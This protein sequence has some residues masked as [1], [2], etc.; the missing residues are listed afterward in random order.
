LPEGV[1]KGRKGKHTAEWP[2]AEER[3]PETAEA[4]AAE[5]K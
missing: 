3:V 1:E 5:M 2:G 4:V